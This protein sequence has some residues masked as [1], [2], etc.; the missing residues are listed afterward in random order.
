MKTQTKTK[1]ER[2]AKQKALTNFVTKTFR[3]IDKQMLN[4]WKV[5]EYEGLIVKEIK[6]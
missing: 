3:N 6:K 4:L 5:L 2:L 1:E